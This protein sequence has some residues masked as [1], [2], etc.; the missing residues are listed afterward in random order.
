MSEEKKKETFTISQKGFLAVFLDHSFYIEIPRLMHS[1]MYHFIKN[2]I[3]RNAELGVGF[4]FV[5]SGF[6]NYVLIA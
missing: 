1:R 5:L 2:G 4:F 3:F 6:F